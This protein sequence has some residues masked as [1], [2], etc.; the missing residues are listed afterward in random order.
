[1]QLRL[2]RER[3]RVIVGSIA[4]I[5]SLREAYDAYVAHVAA[6]PGVGDP[7]PVWDDFLKPPRF[8][9][10]VL[11]VQPSNHLTRTALGAVFAQRRSSEVRYSFD[12]ARSSASP[13][14]TSRMV[15]R[16]VHPGEALLI[17]KSRARTS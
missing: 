8:V 13:G 15:H 1:L 3:A 2:H 12:G 16:L 9:G 10:S 11:I 17:T 5:E 6:H 4:G 14:C 7:L